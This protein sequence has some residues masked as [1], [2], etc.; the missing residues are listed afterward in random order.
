LLE[1]A[2]MPP[3]APVYVFEG[4]EVV[5]SD[6]LL[7]LAEAVA[8][9]F[10]K[11]KGVAAKVGTQYQLMHAF[12]LRYGDFHMAA[13]VTPTSWKI[14]H[15]RDRERFH[16]LPLR[17]LEENSKK[18]GQKR[19]L[20][21]LRFAAGPEKIHIDTVD[22]ADNITDDVEDD[23]GSHTGSIFSSAATVLDDV[24]L[25][26]TSTHGMV[27]RSRARG[28][29]TVSKDKVLDTILEVAKQGS[30]G[31]TR[32][33]PVPRLTTPVPNREVKG[34]KGTPSRATISLVINIDDEEV[35]EYVK[36]RLGNVSLADLLD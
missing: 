27:T 15:G 35:A 29:G 14:T 34:R 6:D 24:T 25:R 17:L 7:P 5:R 19:L 21:G 33:S 20:E 4:I 11:G 30:P 22:D 1:K 26:D 36:S 16:C 8:L 9:T 12:G 2:T 31:S 10:S 23:S 13:E 28:T 18:V 32:V 3:I